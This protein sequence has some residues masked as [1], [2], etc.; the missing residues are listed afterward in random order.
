MMFDGEVRRRRGWGGRDSEA[1]WGVDRVGVGEL[2][3]P[4]THHRPV[5]PRDSHWEQAS[6]VGSDLVV[7][8]RVW[9][10]REM[11]GYEEVGKARGK[12]DSFWSSLTRPWWKTSKPKISGAG[13]I[14]QRTIIHI[15]CTPGCC[16][17]KYWT[18]AM[19]RGWT[20]NVKLWNPLE[21]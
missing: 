15:C 18:R 14:N 8:C 20:V 6:P 19:W 7:F 1:G 12:M 4:T 11:Q 10:E 3:G 5:V 16:Q 13:I 21:I 17:G 9:R 2:G